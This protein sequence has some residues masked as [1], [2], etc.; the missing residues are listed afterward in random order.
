MHEL[1]KCFVVF[2][3]KGVTFSIQKGLVASRS[4]LIPF[5][6][7]DM[8]DLERLLMIQAEEDKKVDCISMHLSSSLNGI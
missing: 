4:R 2:S 7:N 5:E 3:D 8:A 6:H 1:N